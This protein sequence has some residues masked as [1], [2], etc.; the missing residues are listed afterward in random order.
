[1]CKKDLP[2]SEFK[3]HVTRPDGLQAHCISCQ[4][5]Y[6]RQHYI[7][8]R[9][10]Y[11]D[12]A[13]KY[14]KDFVEWF[15]EFKSQLKCNRCDETHPACLQFHHTNPSEK[16]ALVSQLVSNCNKAKIL[17]EI[18]KCE[19]LCANCHAKHHYQRIE[20]TLTLKNSSRLEEKIA[21]NLN[22]SRRGTD[23]SSASCK[24]LSLNASQLRSRWL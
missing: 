15:Q 4:K 6:R 8:N 9:Q 5:E 16:E 19:V 12:K 18:A 21:M 2:L 7:K 11:I 1:M 13:K 20:A 10:K 24:T 23:G 14:S 3:H 22:F 17:K